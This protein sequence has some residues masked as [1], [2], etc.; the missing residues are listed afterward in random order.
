MVQ[1]PNELKEGV[2]TLYP[3]FHIGCL[4]ITANIKSGA[5]FFSFRNRFVP[6]FLRRTKDNSGKRRYLDAVQ[7]EGLFFFFLVQM[8]C[9]GLY[10]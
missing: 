9:D 6:M 3:P 4:P 5:V 1:S 10:S 7:S 8:K 2:G